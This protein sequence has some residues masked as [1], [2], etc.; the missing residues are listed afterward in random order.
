MSGVSR[1]KIKMFPKLEQ[2]HVFIFLL[3]GSVMVFSYFLIR[4][5]SKTLDI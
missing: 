1:C 4:F 5:K 2:C 3:Q